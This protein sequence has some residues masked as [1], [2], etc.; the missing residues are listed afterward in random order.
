VTVKGE[1]RNL[2]SNSILR[3]VTTASQSAGTVTLTWDGRADN[4]AWVAPALYEATITVVDSAGG[5]T[6]LKPLITVRY[7]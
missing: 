2:T 3:T 5:S 1:F 4:G 7:E 6:V